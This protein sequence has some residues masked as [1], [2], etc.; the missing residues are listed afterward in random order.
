M[1]DTTLVS[2]GVTVTPDITKDIKIPSYRTTPSPAAGKIETQIL[3]DLYATL[4]DAEIS[5]NLGDKGVK[6]KQF[7][8]NG[9]IT[10]QGFSSY[11][12]GGTANWGDEITG[13]LNLALNKDK[14]TELS[15]VLS[16]GLSFETEEG[17]KFELYGGEPVDIS[18]RELATGFERISE[19]QFAEEYPKTAL[20][21]EIGGGLTSAYFTRGMFGSPTAVKTIPQLI[22]Q[23]G[24]VG[25]LA[26]FGAGEGDV[27]QQ[28]TSTV[29]GGATGAGLGFGLGIVQNVG[30]K[31]VDWIMSGLR[32]QNAEQR[33]QALE[34]V[35]NVIEM[36]FGSVDE[37][38][39]EF[40]KVTGKNYTLADLSDNPR[41]LLDIAKM[42]PNPNS[43]KAMDF[44]KQ[45]NSGMMTRLQN[46]TTQAFGKRGQLFTEVSAIKA[47]RGD[48]ADK[49]YKRAFQYQ[50]PVEDELVTIL[51]R[52]SM[53]KAYA[54]A[55]ELANEQGVK[56]PKT[57]L[58]GNGRLYAMD[59]AV[60]KKLNLTAKD[61]QDPEK[62]LDL[63]NKGAFKQ[64]DK[65][66]TEFM[67]FLKMGLDDQ[68]FTDKSPMTGV[69]RYM[70]GAKGETRKE[71]L[72]YIDSKNKTYQTARNIFAGDTQVLDSYNLG[73]NI[74]KKDMLDNP[75]MVANMLKNMTRSEKEAFRSGAVS[76]IM[77]AIG[78]VA[79]EGEQL[80]VS[81]DL[82][83]KFIRDPK[84]MRVLKETFKDSPQ[85]WE[86]FQKNLIVESQMFETYTKMFGSQTMPR[87]TAYKEFFGD[88]YNIDPKFN[89]I[90]K[91]TQV[92]S[93]DSRI[94]NQQMAQGVAKEVI[95]IL[96]TYKGKD[97]A[98]VIQELKGVNAPKVIF[99]LLG[100]AR[101]G[102]TS[103]TVTGQQVGERAFD[104]QRGYI[105]NP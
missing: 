101:R 58:G 55:V 64:V 97:L 65:I 61:L 26:G 90:E 41:M 34:K 21:L 27:R 89:P 86:K 100:Q 13:L 25:G 20:G 30:G 66:D 49:L 22:A 19:E 62:L 42:I 38:L 23:T 46:D 57:I 39:V 7:M 104:F 95:D 2:K 94:A 24:L 73:A 59:E 6:L 32:P 18:P 74:F 33:K 5:G 80:L 69:G 78:G 105:P 98:K 43:K 85:A 92:L 82:A 102:L 40:S 8:E 83:K 67:H 88:V 96:T 36:D 48:V 77:N 29:L 56:L 47:A 103:P 93:Q 1:V 50:I 79:E 17:Q 63:V 9:A 52:P 4:Q 31:T 87:A 37:A 51:Q 91:V 68:I 76:S 11:L 84:R 44:L 45:R 28:A 54:A 72:N 75:D 10:P 81:S 71:L 16:G 60:I 53:Q 14:L 12:K 70:L 99:D 15:K 3:R 35:K